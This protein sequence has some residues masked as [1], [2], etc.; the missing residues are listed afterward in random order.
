LI[1]LKNDPRFVRVFD[2]EG[3]MVYRFVG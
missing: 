1:L 3:Y 2:K